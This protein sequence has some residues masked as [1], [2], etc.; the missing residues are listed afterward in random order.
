MS[1]SGSFVP[2]AVPECPYAPRMTRAAAIA[3]AAGGGLLENC[4]VVITDGPVIGT[5]GNTSVTEIELNPVSTTAFGQ[6]A[7]V[8]TTFAP[9]AWPGVYDVALNKITELRDDFGNTAKDID[10]GAATVHTQWPWHLGSATLRDNYAEDATL[11]AMAAQV[12]TITNCRFVGSTVNF[13]GKTAGTWTDTEFVGATVTT[14]AN[15]VATRSKVTGA[16]VTNAGAGAFT[17]TDSRVTDASTALA[18]SGAATGAKTLT[19]TTIRDR[20]RM[21]I[22]GQNVVVLT[23]S[24]F[25]GQGSNPSEAELGGTGTISI[26]DT[27]VM[28]AFG[29]L[30][31]LDLQG[32]GTVTLGQGDMRESRISVAAGASSI[33]TATTFTFRRSGGIIVAA[34]GTGNVVLLQGVF[35]AGG[36]VQQNGAAALSM[37][38]CQGGV[39]LVGAAAATRGATLTGCTGQ[40]LTVTQNG[41]GSANLDNIIQSEGIGSVAI[42]LNSTSAATPAQTFPRLALTAGATLNVI[43][44]AGA[45]PIDNTTI[46]QQATVNLQAGGS[47]SRC[48]VAGEGTLNTGAF[49]HIATTVELQGVTTLTAANVNR[50]RTKSFSDVV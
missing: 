20:F 28:P 26:T 46:E 37:N 40:Q 47:M 33:V 39:S 6:T 22:T 11:T 9:E 24:E 10:A 15:M 35:L 23:G 50:R 49:G 43:D 42:N 31:A 2:A 8:F 12:G 14:G 5:A 44:P 48:R 3:L 21:N 36:S 25:A 30:T 41:T 38:A 18:I 27:T 13:T 7:R 4:V 29:L 17:L 1:T 34:T 45:Q 19:G 32:S 16:T